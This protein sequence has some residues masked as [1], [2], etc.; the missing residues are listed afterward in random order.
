M[1]TT[2]V[3]QLV[4]ES[5][6]V[7]DRL[8]VVV[9]PPQR[10][11]RRLAIGARGPLAAGGTLR[12]KSARKIE[13]RQWRRRRGRCFSAIDDLWSV[14]RIEWSPDILHSSRRGNKWGRHTAC[15]SLTHQSP[16]G[17]DQRPVLAVHLVVEA[18]GIAEVVAV[19]VTT[20]QRG[21]GGAAVDTLTALWKGGIGT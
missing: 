9:P 10:R 1:H 19:A 4:V 5:A 13:T 16:L 15:C 6:R 11:L 3:V 18:T 20:P 7:A 8:A 12:K 17:L 21:R 14:R 2:Y